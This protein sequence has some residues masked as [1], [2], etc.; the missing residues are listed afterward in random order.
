VN[1]QTQTPNPEKQQVHRGDDSHLAPRHVVPREHTSLVQNFGVRV[2]GL[3]LRN[4]GSGFKIWGL[5]L[6]FRVQG[7]GFSV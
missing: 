5:G 3:T 2:K 6:G 4:S 7:E 1:R